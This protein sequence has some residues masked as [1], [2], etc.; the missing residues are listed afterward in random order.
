[1]KTTPIL[2]VL[3]L[4][5]AATSFAQG[6]T[7]RAYTEFT[8]VSP[9]SGIQIKGVTETGLLYGAFYQHEVAISSAIDGAE[10]PK[11]RE[12]SFAGIFWGFHLL[13]TERVTLDFEVRSGVRNGKYFTITPAV[14]GQ[15][16]ITEQLSLSAGVGTRNFLPTWIGGLEFNLGR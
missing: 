10:T 14:M 2:V 9:K 3:L 12:R 16:Q 1:M 4:A 13:N 7:V 5:F 6:V 11:F 15:I 8:R